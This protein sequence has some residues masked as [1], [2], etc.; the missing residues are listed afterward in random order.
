MTGDVSFWKA[1]GKWDELRLYFHAQVCVGTFFFRGRTA[2]PSSIFSLYSLSLL[3]PT[4]DS[5]MGVWV[6]GCM[7][8]FLAVIDW[9]FYIGVTLTAFC[10]RGPVTSSFAWGNVFFFFSAILFHFSFYPNASLCKW[11]DFYAHYV[12]GEW[13]LLILDTVEKMK[14]HCSYSRTV[15][16]TFSYQILKLKKWKIKMK[17]WGKKSATNNHC[18]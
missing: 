5:C 4:L 10:W 1:G 13:F 17:K 2:H 12:R 9:Q 14:H 6:Y 15:W 16:P 18:H 8:V 3:T 7:G 11:K